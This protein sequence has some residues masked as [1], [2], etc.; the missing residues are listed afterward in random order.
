MNDVDL[1]KAFAPEIETAMASYSMPVSVVGANQPTEQGAN[2]TATIYF[3]KI[4][5]KRI[6]LPRIAKVYNPTEGYFDRSVSQKYESTF[7][8]DTM[9]RKTTATT[10]T[11]SDYL[12]AVAMIM[13]SIDFIKTIKSKGI[14]ML[15][16]TEVRDPYFKDDKNQFQ[17]NPSFDFTIVYN[18][19]MLSTVKKISTVEHKIK[20]V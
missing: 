13:N 9:I 19:A 5:D 4:G 18:R 6:G 15:R 7:Q 3:Q 20:G 11:N 16:I 12:N 10:I 2:S 1:I 8:I 17:S 14:T